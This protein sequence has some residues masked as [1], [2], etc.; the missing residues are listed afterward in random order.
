MRDL[1]GIVLWLVFRSRNK[2]R[3]TR[4]FNFFIFPV[5]IVNRLSFLIMH[6]QR[7]V[8]KFILIVIVIIIILGYLGFNLRDIMESEGVQNNLTYAWDQVV[9]VWE[10]WLKEPAIWFWNN[11]WIP[12]I[13]EPFVN[14]M[15]SL[16]DNPPTE[17]M[18]APQ[19]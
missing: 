10:T 5:F 17:A 2:C 18:E 15:E 7:G 16:K 13:W 1:E 11:I 6:T 8:I 14:V 19:V 3:M 9:Y 4:V 12:Y